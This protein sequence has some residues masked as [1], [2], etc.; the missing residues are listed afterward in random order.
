V[1]RE[2][3]PLLDVGDP[4]IQIHHA[5]AAE[6]P[7]AKPPI[8]GPR[9]E[10]GFRRPDDRSEEFANLLDWVVWLAGTWRGRGGDERFVQGEKKT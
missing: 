3:L 5:R 1:L 10:L 9:Y 2:V 4:E 8:R 7:S 6:I